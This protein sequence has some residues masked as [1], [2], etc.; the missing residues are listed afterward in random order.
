MASANKNR[1]DNNKLVAVYSPAPLTA[2]SGRVCRIGAI[3]AECTSAKIN[4]A[5]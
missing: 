1:M 5:I 3:L 2:G 4:V